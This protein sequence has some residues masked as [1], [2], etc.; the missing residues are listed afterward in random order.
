MRIIKRS[1]EEPPPGCGA[2]SKSA[3]YTRYT[4]NRTWGN[5]VVTLRGSIA[6]KWPEAKS[7][8][9]VSSF[10]V[11]I[12]RG[13]TPFAECPT[14]VSVTLDARFS[15][16]LPSAPPKGQSESLPTSRSLSLA[17]VVENGRTRQRG[18]RSLV[19]TEIKSSTDI[20]RRIFRILRIPF[21]AGFH[22]N[23]AGNSTR[24]RLIDHF[25]GKEE[26]N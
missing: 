25:I 17:Q 5:F 24:A 19:A 9:V 23:V 12:A 15:A 8:D 4:Y 22:G 13:L 3:L 10:A 1:R 6:G 14:S 21:S 20:P 11:V 26:K 16:P 7:D 18:T 2:R